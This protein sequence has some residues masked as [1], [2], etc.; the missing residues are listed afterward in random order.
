MKVRINR[1]LSV[2]FLF[3]PLLFSVAGFGYES[4][5]KQ[6]PDF[7]SVQAYKLLSVEKRRAYI[8]DLR[9]L[10][11]ETEKVFKKRGLSYADS[12]VPF[13]EIFDEIFFPPTKAMSGQ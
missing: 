5:K 11:L 1:F 13:R 7:L 9:K 12:F 10:F 4:P 2:A 8:L 6:K 3:F